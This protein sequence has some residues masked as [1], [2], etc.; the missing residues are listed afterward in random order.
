MVLERIFGKTF[1]VPDPGGLKKV[2]L[3]LDELIDFASEDRFKERMEEAR[4]Y[5]YFK[6]GKINDDDPDFLQR[7]NTFLE[8][9]VFD[10]R[11]GGAGEKSL[12]DVYLGEK[13]PTL[14]A[15]EVVMRI[16]ASKNHHSIF[17]VRSH[18]SGTVKLVDMAGKNSFV[19]TYDDELEEKDIIEARVI[20]VGRGCFLSYAHCLHPK[21]TAKVIYAQIKRRKGAPLDE[22]FFFRL[23]GMQLKW[24][25]FRQI[26][27][28]NIY[29]F[30]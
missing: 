7:M 19:V 23:Q 28:D 26:H 1:G 20:S 22:E 17:M 15:D 21:T 8:W 9:F 2:R 5:Y 13:L 16:A 14:S 4:A 25:R 30:N 29:N 10:H 24:R 6:A 12:F 27:V 3:M 18:G 11:P